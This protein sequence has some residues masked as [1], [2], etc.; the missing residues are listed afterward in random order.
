M[1]VSSV[2]LVALVLARPIGTLQWQSA[3]EL[4][5]FIRSEYRGPE[6]AVEAERTLR[7]ATAAHPDDPSYAGVYGSWLF[8]QGRTG[9]AYGHLVRACRSLKGESLCTAA[10]ATD[11]AAGRWHDAVSIAAVFPETACY[12]SNRLWVL[13]HLETDSKRAVERAKGLIREEPLH[14][15]SYLLLAAAYHL[16]H[17]DQ[18]AAEQL[19]IGRQR[20]SRIILLNQV[21]WEVPK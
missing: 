15:V 5:E 1:T 13:K 12:R 16:S 6:S 19:R 9:D 4:A 20:A 7:D 11:L 2:L 8:L 10:A 3:K 18:R 17:D 21:A 14:E